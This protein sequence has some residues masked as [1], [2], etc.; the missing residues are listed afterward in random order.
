MEAPRFAGPQQSLK[1]SGD[2]IV[3]GGEAFNYYVDFNDR[4]VTTDIDAKFVPFM[5]TNTKYF[6][7]LQALKLL[8][9]D[10]LGKYAKNLNDAP[11]APPKATSNKL[12]KFSF[13][14]VVLL[15]LFSF[16]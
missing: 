4:I 13:E 6:G 9:W 8:L 1:S 3:S 14:E 7:K 15:Q 10:M 11:R 16:Q 2:L 5:K 12:S